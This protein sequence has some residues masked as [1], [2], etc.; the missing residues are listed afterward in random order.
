MRS[1]LLAA[2]CL[3]SLS[4]A[5]VSAQET[6]AREFT[7]TRESNRELAGTLV[8]P[9]V[10]SQREPVLIVA[11]S[12]PTDRDGNSPLGV[13][14]ATYRLLAEGLAARGVPTLRTD[15]R[16]VGSSRAALVREDDSTVQLGADDVRAW[17]GRLREATNARCVWLLGHSEGALL[18]LLAAQ[19]NDEVCGLV[20]VSALGRP[21]ADALR[22]QLHANPANEPLLEQALKAIAEL[23]AGRRFDVSGMHPALLPLF[24]PSVQPHLISLFAADPAALVRRYAG[25]VLVMQGT[26]DLQTTVKDAQ[27]LGNAR[28]GVEVALLDG[29]NHVLK[30]APAERPANLATYRDPNLPLA[31]GVVDRIATFLDKHAPPRAAR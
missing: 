11:G 19:A 25:P 31:A 29:V 26:T 21:A 30:Q 3:G 15:K 6:R 13:S 24:R 5:A 16:G 18:A 10:P 1:A 20:L 2:A 12:G 17:I 28:P 4:C 27:R 23:E 14:A 8:V 22:E 9:V 7:V